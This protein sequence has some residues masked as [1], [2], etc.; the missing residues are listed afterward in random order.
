MPE[1]WY[2]VEC[3]GGGGRTIRAAEA[4]ALRASVADRHG[5]VAILILPKG[6]GGTKTA[7]GGCAVYG[8]LVV[9]I[10]PGPCH[11]RTCSNER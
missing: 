4:W 1:T 3:T 8:N 10:K 5:E 7:Q 2:S 6:K 11:C 9:C